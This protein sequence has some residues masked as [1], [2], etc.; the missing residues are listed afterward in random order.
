[1][2]KEPARQSAPASGKGDGLVLTPGGHRPGAEFHTLS[3]DR[4]LS[5][6]GNRIRIMDAITGEVAEDLGEV[7]KE[8]VG[9]LGR[10]QRSRVPSPAGGGWVGWAQWKN[11]SGSPIVHFSTTWDVPPPPLTSNGQLIYIFNGLEPAGKNWIIQPVL[12]WGSSPAGGGEF[13]AIT[14]WF[15]NSKGKSIRG[16][17][18]IEVAPETP[19]TTVISI[20]P[21]VATQT[22]NCVSSFVGHPDV[23]LTVT[24]VSRPTW[25]YE[26]LECHGITGCSDYPDVG[27]IVMSGIQLTVSEP[28]DSD[29]ILEWKTVTNP[30]FRGCAIEWSVTDR[31]AA[32][33]SIALSVQR[34]AAAKTSR[35]PGDPVDAPLD[36]VADPG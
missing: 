12:Q 19:L 36:A 30:R 10:S 8:R 6:K 2:L 34:P 27:S 35:L 16:G 5:L 25:A 24:D 9:R 11:N 32:E 31:S 17:P 33:G 7:S 1:M 26:T 3:Q 15:V 22:Y 4:Q 14:N 28:T 23:D 18:L 29:G 13:W 20:E 21:Q